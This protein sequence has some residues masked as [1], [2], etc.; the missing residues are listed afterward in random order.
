MRSSPGKIRKRPK[1]RAI[2]QRMVAATP[3]DIDYRID[4]ARTELIDLRWHQ[5]Q[6]T[7]RDEELALASEP[8]NPLLVERA[9]E[10]LETMRPKRPNALKAA[11]GQNPLLT[12]EMESLGALAERIIAAN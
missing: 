5:R 4:L 10:Q 2:F 1:S 7:L 6:E 8:L 3:W 12:K 9:I 11:S